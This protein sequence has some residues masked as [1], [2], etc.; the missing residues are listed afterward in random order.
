M[1]KKKKWVT[2]GTNKSLV[3]FP[4]WKNYILYFFPSTVSYIFPTIGRIISI[5][6]KFYNITRSL[7]FY[8]II[9]TFFTIDVALFSLHRIARFF[10][11]IHFILSNSL[12]IVWRISAYYIVCSLI[13]YTCT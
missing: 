8:V 2:N 6:I 10:F 3:V 12:R 5:T 13:D 1:E 7:Y 11:F 4:R 9:F